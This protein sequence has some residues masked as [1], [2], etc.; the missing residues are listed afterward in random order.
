[1]PTPQWARLLN[2][3]TQEYMREEEVN[4]LRERKLLAMMESRGRVSMNHSGLFADWKVRYKRSPMQ[5]YADADTLTFARQNR[6]KTAQLDWRG[7]ASPESI[8]RLEEL[9]NKGEPA[10][11]KFAG[12]LAGLMVEDVTENFGDEMYVDGSAAGNGKRIHGLESCLGTS[13]VATNGFVGLPNSTYAGIVCTLGNYGGSWSTVSGNVDWPSGT[14]D[15]HYDFFSPLIVSYTNASWAASTKT[16]PNTCREA[17][18][19]GIIKSRRNKSKK[20]ALDLILLE[21][22]LYRNFEDKVEANERLV[23]DRGG[24]KKGGLTALGFGD[25][26]NYDGVDITYEYGI[27]SA[28]GYG[29]A[30]GAIELCSL[31]DRLFVVDGPDP[32][33]SGLSKRMVITFF[34]NLKMNPRM[35]LAFKA[36]G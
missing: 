25:V 4:V 12:E 23:V 1:M 6:W 36:L 29:L 24:T 19:F 28:T 14:G 11:I 31:Q 17:T 3:T 15:Y 16:W 9:Q 5:G 10:I 26:L 33:I 27:P 21:N 22:E 8:T 30:M 35:I 32:D 13:G 34:G 7:Y 18:R 20:G 2:T